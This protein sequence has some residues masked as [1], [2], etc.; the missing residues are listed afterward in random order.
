M[1][2]RD[3]IA[4][5]AS[6]GGVEAVR[7]VVRQLPSDFPASVFVVVHTLP[8]GPG[9]L[10]DLLASAGPLPVSV[11]RP[12][13]PIRPGQIYVA[14]P[15]HHL[16]LD[17]GWVRTWRGPREN[18]HRP[19]VDTLFRSA[20]LQYRERVAGVLLTGMLDDGT[21]GLTA[22]KAWH[23]VAIVQDPSDALAP[24]MPRSALENVPVD[25][26]LPV[27]EIG[28]VL[29][30]LACEGDEV[31]VSRRTNPIPHRPRSLVET[32]DRP[33]PFACPS[34]G[35]VLWELD[36]ASGWFR[37]RCRV[38]H[39]YAPESLLAD[40]ED[41]LEQALWSSLRSLEELADLRERLA[42]HHEAHGEHSASKRLQ[43]EAKSAIDGA[44][45]LRRLLLSGEGTASG[46]SAQRV[47]R[48]GVGY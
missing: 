45:E 36:E 14:P 35:G 3:I 4:I 28:S 19:A 42:E 26:R 43:E 46:A 34:C 11:P 2:R 7:D 44:R 21:A 1:A 24:G 18:R 15:D 23:G 29:A 37:F 38:G 27:T 39:A 5:G 31:A 17:D 13:A 6:M 12:S 40:Q 41:H 32:G 33:S 47:A 22:I 16:V 8:T 25:Y 48:E 10:P 9:L 30:R 20:A